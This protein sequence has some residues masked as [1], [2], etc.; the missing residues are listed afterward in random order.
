MKTTLEQIRTVAV[1]VAFANVGGVATAEHIFELVPVDSGAVLPGDDSFVPD[2]NDGSYFTFDLMITT[3]PGTHFDVA[4][5][6]A[7]LTGSA[8]FFQH[9][10]GGPVPPD[11]SVIA[12]YPAVEF[13]S[14]FDG[15]GRP[16][17]IVDG[18]LVEEPQFIHAAWYGGASYPPAGTYRVARFSFRFLEAGAATL[19][20]EGRSHDP[21]GS[22]GAWWPIGPL[23]VTVEYAPEPGALALLTLGGIAALRR[24]R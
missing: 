5:A 4:E 22:G 13:D 15:G 3:T 7:M 8:Q 11:D 23:D 16:V 19:A 20:V 21:L 2:F 14:Y 10:A 24:R 6:D 1:I 18:S 12:Q 17:A 9:A